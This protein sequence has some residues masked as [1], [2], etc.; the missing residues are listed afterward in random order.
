MKEFLI[1]LLN[2][3]GF[4]CWIEV[5]TDKPNCT[6]Y[7]GPFISTSEAKDALSGYIED[8]EHEGAQGIKVEIKR[9]RPINLTIFDELGEMASR[10]GTPIFSGQM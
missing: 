2:L 3:L 7:F 6:Y 1:S 8:L 10:G 9:C 4:A 5:V